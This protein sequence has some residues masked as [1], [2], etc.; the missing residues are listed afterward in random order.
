MTR[1]FSQ[2][3]Y[4]EL[5]LEVLIFLMSINFLHYGQLFL[6]IIALI[7][8]IDHR[9]K[10][11]NPLILI[12]SMLFAISFFYF[13]RNL[14]FY[15]V[16]GFCLPFAVYIGSCIDT[17]NSASLKKLIYIIGFGMAIHVVLNFAYE[18]IFEYHLNYSFL[19]K[20]PNHFD[21]WTRDHIKTTGTAMN[22]FILI[23]ISYYLFRYEKNRLLNVLGTI[24]FALLMV[25]NVALGKRMV[26]VVALLSFLIGMTIDFLYVGKRKPSFGGIA[27]CLLLTAGILGLAL[28]AYQLNLF[29]IRDLTIIKKIV[30]MGLRAERLIIYSWG[31]PLLGTHL[32]GGQEI[33]KII[34]IQF[35]DLF[36]DIYDYA[37]IISFVLII[38]LVAV[39]LIGVVKGLRK[40]DK[41]IRIMAITVT[42]I[43]MVSFL[44]EP[45]MTGE[46]L[47]LICSLLIFSTIASFARSSQA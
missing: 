39:L 2:N 20:K 26:Y 6:P 15:S 32:W 4:L 35:H 18:L 23:A 37:G 17:S 22:M 38:A 45:V 24:V 46:S 28:I 21:V 40:V 27:G 11:R 25:Y 42:V 19:F 13:S 44:I 36:F 8:F 1:I 29:G 12:V 31:F 7:L 5:V 16:M 30:N 9:G 34:G 10:I 3:K 43:I 33:S 47:Y 14:G 41:K